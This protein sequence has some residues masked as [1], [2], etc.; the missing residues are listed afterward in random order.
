MRKHFPFFL[1][2]LFAQSLFAD[3]IPW[4]VTDYYS[5]SDSSTVRVEFVLNYPAVSEIGNVAGI[6]AELH[7]DPAVFSNP[8]IEPSPSVMSHPGLNGKLKGF[9]V[10]GFMTEPGIFRFTIACSPIENLYAGFMDLA[11]F[12]FTVDD[13]AAYSESEKVF[14]F[15]DSL[16]AKCKDETGALT[17]E[18]FDSITLAPFEIKNRANDWLL[19]E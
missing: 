4:N 18:L 15:T 3:P 14:S 11:Y 13:M 19:Y 1:F 8:Q 17:R 5:F 9:Q 10:G 2:L 6:S 12:I 7:Y 16:A